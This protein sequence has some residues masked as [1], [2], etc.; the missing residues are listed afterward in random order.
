MLSL[1]RILLLVVAAALAIGGLFAIA[2][3][4]PGAIVTG[5]VLIGAGALLALAVA[6]ER[7]RY[8]SEAAEQTVA[9]S[10]PGG[11]SSETPLDPRFRL[12]DEVF[13]DPSSG[14]R[15]R[16]YVDGQ[17]GERRYRAEG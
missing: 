2:T 5:L 14:R 11:D 3:A 13:V 12:T 6:Y 8:R 10:G 7:T 17:T 16:V 9:P 15:M 1:S 4:D